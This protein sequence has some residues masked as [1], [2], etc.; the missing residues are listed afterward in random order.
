[1]GKVVLGV[2]STANFM[3][4]RFFC[5]RTERLQAID[6]AD[7]EE[8]SW[9]GTAGNLYDLEGSGEKRGRR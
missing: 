5:E 6:I 9:C 2:T 4:E 8:W 1:M 7:G 3:Q